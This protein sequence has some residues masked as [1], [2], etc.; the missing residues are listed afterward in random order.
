MDGV[1]WQNDAGDLQSNLHARVH[2]G[3]FR[4]Q[5]SR[6]KYIRKS[7]GRQRPLGIASVEEHHWTTEKGCLSVIGRDCR[8]ILPS[9]MN[10]K[11][12]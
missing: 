6:R 5:P 9:G 2:Q 11:P 7:D 10:V 1:V 3:V 12:R 8:R 4:A